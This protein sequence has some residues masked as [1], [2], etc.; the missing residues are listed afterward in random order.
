MIFRAIAPHVLDS[1]MFGLQTLQH[2]MRVTRTWDACMSM[3][4]KGGTTIWGDAEWSPEEGYDCSKRMS[5][6]GT[7]APDE[8]NSTSVHL[9]AH[10]KP[11]AHYGRLISFGKENAQLPLSI[12]DE[13]RK[14]QKVS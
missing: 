8:K 12:I 14:K 1:D 11:V 13:R 9:G 4:P 5:P 7:G 3:I 6:E 2:M 10:G